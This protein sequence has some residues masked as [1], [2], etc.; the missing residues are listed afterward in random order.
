MSRN[1]GKYIF[2][3][4]NLNKQYNEENKTDLNKENDFYS[5]MQKKRKRHFSNRKNHN[6]DK[7]PSC[8]S[9]LLR[10]Y[11]KHIH[12]KNNFPYVN[13]INEQKRLENSLNEE[14][15]DEFK[16]QL[17][18]K[19]ISNEP[20][21]NLYPQNINN[22]ID[23]NINE[24]Y[25]DNIININEY[26]NNHYNKKIDNHNIFEDEKN[27]EDFRNN[28]SGKK[29]LDNNIKINEI[30]D[31]NKNYDYYENDS[32]SDSEKNKNEKK[33][34]IECRLI[35]SSQKIKK[36]KKP[37]KKKPIIISVEKCIAPLIKKK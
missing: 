2:L 35:K 11:Y 6:I 23:N 30:Y 19:K 9:S 29:M 17:P 4:S 3:L 32:I 14:Q 36:V 24:N 18:N 26:D 37:K 1:S 13:N 28:E 8:A 10:K 33:N 34:I 21:N 16:Q 20:N 27:D 31:F 7:C 5:L 15:I 22:F 25:Q 12:E